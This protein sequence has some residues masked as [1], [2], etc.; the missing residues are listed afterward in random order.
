VIIPM[1]RIID[2]GG[3]P[4]SGVGDGLRQHRWLSRELRFLDTGRG[5]VAQSPPE[6]LQLRAQPIVF[7]RHGFNGLLAGR[8]GVVDDTIVPQE[9]AAPAGGKTTGSMFVA[10]PINEMDDVSPDRIFV[11]HKDRVLRRLDGKHR[12]AACLDITANAFLFIRTMPPPRGHTGGDEKN[13]QH[14]NAK[15]II[16]HGTHPNRL[17]TLEKHLPHS[18]PNHGLF[19]LKGWNK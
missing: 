1:R 7:F 19:S 16:C 9:N 2:G 12:A 5:P 18:S 8:I 17:A 10:M 11:K 4:C 15:K 13:D 14:A 6:R 3:C